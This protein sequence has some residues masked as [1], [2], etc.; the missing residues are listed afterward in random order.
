[1]FITLAG[2]EEGQRYTDESVQHLIR[3][4][5]LCARSYHRFSRPFPLEH[6]Q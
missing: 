2:D 3:G 4:I 1:M 5:S 6:I